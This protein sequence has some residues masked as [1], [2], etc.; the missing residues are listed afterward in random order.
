MTLEFPTQVSTYD[1]G[2]YENNAGYIRE[3]TGYTTHFYAAGNCAMDLNGYHDFTIKDGNILGDGAQQGTV[4]F[5]DSTTYVGGRLPTITLIHTS[6]Q[7]MGNA[8]GGPINTLAYTGS[9]TG[10]CT[11]ALCG[12]YIKLN[13][14][15][16][17]LGENGWSELGNITDAFN[18]NSTFNADSCG[19]ISGYSTTTTDIL[20]IGNRFEAA[21]YGL[22]NTCPPGGP[23]WLV[24]GVGWSDAGSQFEVN[25]GPDI[26]L[27]TGWGNFHKTGG[28]F[29]GAGVLGGS[30][31]ESSI[32]LNAASSAG[33]ATIDSDWRLLNGTPKYAIEGLDAQISDNITLR[34]NLGSNGYATGLS[35]FTAGTPPHFS[36]FA[37]GETPTIYSNPIKFGG[38]ASLSPTT[39][40]DGLGTLPVTSTSDPFNISTGNTNTMVVAG[41]RINTATPS[42]GSGYSAINAA[43]YL[44]T[45]YKVVSSVQTNLSVTVGTGAGTTQ[46]AIGD[47]IV[48]SSSLALDGS[49]A[50]NVTSGTSATESLTTA[51][52]ND[53]IVVFVEANATGSSCTGPNPT[54]TSITSTHIG[55]FTRRKSFKTSVTCSEIEEWAAIA[56]SVLT[57]EI[58]T[59][60]FSQSISFATISV[61]GVSHIIP[62]L[63][64]NFLSGGNFDLGLV[65]TACPCVVENPTNPTLAS[66]SNGEIEI[67]QS[68][69]GSDTVSWGSNWKFAG[70]SAPS[71]STGASDKDYFPFYVKDAT[72]IIVSAGT[73]NAH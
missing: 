51:N 32:L 17:D 57:S 62:T 2:S 6:V 4:Q 33:G 56:P 19:I 39:A 30:G 23:A 36:V 46:T 60:N 8:A 68:A 40:F 11:G 59:I 70:G 54:I 55:N 20:S 45:E 27:T 64:P 42:A 15:D 1:G 12:N 48:G 9:A 71:L 52:G 13:V 21:G 14:F 29:L 67:D 16:S 35:N 22:A 31:D 66:G 61:F 41:F 65:H 24:T 18:Y 58:I 25:N 10:T 38:V 34:G 7:L 47:A 53:E 37:N 72:D 5:C 3:N 43:N 28:H 73:I 44:L 50:S 69:T 49:A 26:E 63:T